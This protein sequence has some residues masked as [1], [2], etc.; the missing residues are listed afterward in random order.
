MPMRD[1]AIFT[2][3]SEQVSAARRVA[4]VMPVRKM[5][6]LIKFI[7]VDNLPRIVSRQ[8]NYLLLPVR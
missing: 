6:V 5:V 8:H 2:T 4:R 1:G 7:K 3:G